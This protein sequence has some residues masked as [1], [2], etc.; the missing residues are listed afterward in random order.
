M[1]LCNSLIKL[2]IVSLTLLV[3]GCCILLPCDRGNHVG[4]YVRDASGRPIAG[5]SVEFYGVTH[6]TDSD[7]CF[8]FG[9]TLAAPGFQLSVSKGGYKMY[10]GGRRFSFYEINVTLE[11]VSGSPGSKAEWKELTINQVDASPSCK[12]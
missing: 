11:E 9:G 1:C 10:K 8:F 12:K 2:L 7:G 4:G 5:A 6:A 3:N